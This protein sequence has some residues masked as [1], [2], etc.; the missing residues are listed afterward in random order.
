MSCVKEG[1]VIWQ[2]KTTDQKPPTRDPLSLI[3]GKAMV[4]ALSKPNPNPSRAL[5]SLRLK[6]DPTIGILHQIPQGLIKTP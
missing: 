1:R 3:P 6:R 5:M 4:P 2:S